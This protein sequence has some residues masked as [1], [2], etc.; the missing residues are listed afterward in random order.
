MA[1]FVVA[2][3]VAK[4]VVRMVLDR[5]GRRS[6][7]RVFSG[8]FRFSVV[9]IG[10]LFSLTLAFPSVRVADV[11]ALFGIISVA[12]CFA[13]KDTFENLLAG[14]CCYCVTRSCPETR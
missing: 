7:I 9:L 3:R 5:R 10:C 4:P 1:A 11:L 8:L 2:A 14:C 6:Y 13:F 12:A